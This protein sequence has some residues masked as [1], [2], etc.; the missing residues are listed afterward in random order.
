MAKESGL[1]AGFFLAGYDFGADVIA[2]RELSGGP[3]LLEGVTGITMSGHERL[4]GQLTGAQRITVWFNP[5]ANMSHKRLSALPVGAQQGQYWHRTAIGR[6]VHSMIGRQLNHDGNRDKDGSFTFDSD[7]VSDSFGGEWGTGLT[8]GKRV[9][10]VATNGAGV[11]FTTPAFAAASTFGAQFYLQ[12]FALT[13]TSCT[14]TIEDS[15]DNVSFAAVTG[16]AFTAFTGPGDQRLQTA[17]GATVRRYLRA[18]TSGTFS[19][20]TF[21]VAA[22]RNDT[23]VNL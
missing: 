13:G 11:D 4:G 21:A 19:S 20:A 6:P 12:S 22:V 3:A 5:T 8:A 9:D 14:V 15:A 2:I 1:G 10:T 7:L 16:G 18:V 23:L 17:R